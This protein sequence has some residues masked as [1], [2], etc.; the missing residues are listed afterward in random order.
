MI[1]TIVPISKTK[2]WAVTAKPPTRKDT[3]AYAM[4][5]TIKVVEEKYALEKNVI[6]HYMFGIKPR[7]DEAEALFKRAVAWGDSQWGKAELLE[8]RPLPGVPGGL[9]YAV[10]GMEHTRTGN[11]PVIVYEMTFMNGHVWSS[12]ALHGCNRDKKGQLYDIAN[13]SSKSTRV[14]WVVVKEAEALKTI[15]GPKS[16]MEVV[17]DAL[18]HRYLIAHPNGTMYGLTHHQHNIGEDDYEDRGYTH[19]TI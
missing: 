13:Y 18:P 7:G 16:R 3:V 12:F 10:A 14:C 5:T 4:S 19:F 11:K 6:A 15:T 2:G 1:T 9:C 8:N 17:V